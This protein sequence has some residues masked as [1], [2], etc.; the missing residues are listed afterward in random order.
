M[1][2][3]FQPALKRGR[4]AASDLRGC[5]DPSE[6]LSQVTN[7]VERRRMQNRISQRNYRN[8]IRVRLEK[9]EAAVVAQAKEELQAS[10]EVKP[11]EA[12]EPRG[13]AENGPPRPVEEATSTIQDQSL[14]IT[15]DPSDL[16]KCI[17]DFL[18]LSDTDL[19]L[20]NRC[21][22]PHM[23]NMMP[24]LGNSQMES[25][26]SLSAFT[27]SDGPESM[28]MSLPSPGIPQVRPPITHIDTAKPGD[29]GVN[30]G[31]P[32]LDQR[33]SPSSPNADILNPQVANSDYSPD[34]PYGQFS[35]AYPL[36][37]IA[38]IMPL[39]FFAIPSPCMQ[40]RANVS[41]YSLPG[42]QPMQPPYQQYMWIPTPMVGLP[43]E[44]MQPHET[45]SPGS[46]A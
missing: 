13:A 41:R 32:A 21:H 43:M 3:D 37:M 12:P 15:S 45:S 31:N 9:L 33:C 1:S 23:Q 34:H 20:M 29:P 6:E 8:K 2:T 19:E 4:T 27:E 18:N 30:M 28:Y 36:G 11:S 14:K 22:C 24:S 7:L 44:A 40:D 17:P 46:G 35:Y 10:G 42:Y 25:T 38:P 39:G 26:G 16:C 5:Q